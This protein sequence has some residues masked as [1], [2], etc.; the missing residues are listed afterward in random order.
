M[1]TL[2]DILYSRLVPILGSNTTKLEYV[3]RWSACSVNLCTTR[4]NGHNA[5]VFIPTGIVPPEAFP[6]GTAIY[7][8]GEARQNSL[9]RLCSKPFRAVCFYINA[10]DDI[11]VVVGLIKT[12]FSR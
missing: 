11:D 2:S 4:K 1:E 3:I 8:S 9:S 5:R 7:Y 10:V 6:V 12:Y